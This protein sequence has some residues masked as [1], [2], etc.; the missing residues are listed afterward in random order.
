MSS[1]KSM[2]EIIKR[3][4]TIQKFD[5]NKIIKA[6]EAAFKDVKH[7]ISDS[8]HALAVYIA[9]SISEIQ[10]TLTVEQIQ[11]KVESLLMLNLI[12]III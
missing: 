9:K 2:L 5:E 12:K 11:D 8:D 10:E 1:L 3:D 6:V 4:G 7:T